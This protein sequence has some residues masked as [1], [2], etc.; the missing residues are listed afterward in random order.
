LEGYYKTNF[1]LLQYH[2][3]SLSE[4]E[5]LIPW[6]REVYIALLKQYLQEQEAKREANK[7]K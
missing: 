7:N 1:A 2:K 5:N 6:E 3:Y 4:V